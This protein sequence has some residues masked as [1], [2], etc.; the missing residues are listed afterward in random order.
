MQAIEDDNE[1]EADYEALDATYEQLKANGVRL[2]APEGE[3]V[4][5]FLLHI[6]GEN[7]WFRYSEEPFDD[8]S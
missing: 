7:A 8:E 6:D 3:P 4:T 1:S 2:L 5:E